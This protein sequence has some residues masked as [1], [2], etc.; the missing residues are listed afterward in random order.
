MTSIDQAGG[1]AKSLMVPYKQQKD[2]GN[3]AVS[4]VIVSL[5]IRNCSV[6]EQETAGETVLQECDRNYSELK[7][8]TVT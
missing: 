7:K 1:D 2:E 8:N 6:K 5:G 3:V 4:L